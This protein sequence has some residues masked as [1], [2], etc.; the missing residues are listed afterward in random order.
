MVCITDVRF[1]EEK[2]GFF[3]PLKRSNIKN[4]RS[5]FQ[6][7]DS[8]FESQFEN[9]TLD[10]EL[11]THEA[12]LRLAWI[13]VRKYGLEKA[14]KNLCR[15]IAKFD[16]IFGDGTKFNITLTIASAKT[17]H[18]FK[19]K[20]LSETFPDFISEFPRLRSNFKDILAC[21]YGIDILKNEKAKRSYLEPDLQP[22]E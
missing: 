7:T 9:C 4:M 19:Q 11:F 2:W 22:F 14:E 12:H 6:L 17:I 13:H 1:F 18:H 15:Q 8:E 16:T 10:P 21:H 20:T 5:H 3:L